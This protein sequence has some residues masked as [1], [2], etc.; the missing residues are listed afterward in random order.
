MIEPGF[1]KAAQ[2]FSDVLAQEPAGTSAQLVVRQHGKI[3]LDVTGSA[4]STPPIS[5][6]TPF[7]VFSV[8]KVFTGMAVMRLVEE[9]RVELDA[10]IECY[11]PKFAQRGKEGATIRHALLHQAGIPAPHLRQQVFLWPF[12][13]LVTRELEFEAAVFPPGTQTGYHLVNFGFILGEV[14]RRVTGLPIDQYLRQT[15]FAPMG[16]TNTWMRI[17]AAELKRSPKLVVSE[18]LAEEGR[19]F[20]LPIIRKALIP[21]ACLHSN[22]RG[23]GAFFQMLLNG[24]ELD[25]KRYLRPETISM[26]ARTH[27]SG[28]D[29]YL[30]TDMNWGLGFIMGSSPAANLE[31]RKQALGW[32]SCGETFSGMGMGTC[33]AWADRKAGLVTAFTTNSMLGDSAVSTRW[34]AISN[35]VWDCMA[36]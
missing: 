22:A 2:V 27:Y 24:G 25:G 20:N 10:P 30:K 31:P 29:I 15:F 12:W 35:A 14:V 13:G 36:G 19:L 34:A 9:G 5:A 28:P 1:E 3:V 16:L 26:A 6:D 21:A 8:S 11:W 4:P 33:L 18:A 32:G 23:L 7:L 17:P